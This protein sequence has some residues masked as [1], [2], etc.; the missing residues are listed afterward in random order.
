MILQVQHER[1]IHAAHLRPA[2]EIDEREKPKTV[3]E[4]VQEDRDKI[5]LVGPG[6]AVETVVPAARGPKETAAVYRAVEGRL[7][8]VR[9]R[10]QVGA[11]QAVGQRGRIPRGRNWRTGEIVEGSNGARLAER[12]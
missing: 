2:G 6:V 4:F 10:I 9:T 11:A 8:I 3:A 5:D 7:N 1:V 12:G